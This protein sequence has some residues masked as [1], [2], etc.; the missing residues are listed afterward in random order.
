M[1][2][3]KTLLQ[4]HIRD[5]PDFPKPGILFKDITPALQDPAALRAVIDHLAAHYA[6]QS[7]DVIV[8]IESRGF[9]FG[10]ALAYAMNKGI[11]LVRKPGKLPWKTH[12]VSY[13]LEYGQDTLQ[14]H[15][16]AVAPGQRV[17]IVDDLLAT[18]GTAE[19]TCQLVEQ[20][21]GVVAG[22]AFLVELSFLEGRARLE[23]KAPYSILQ[24]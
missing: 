18:G 23:G 10:T 17:L 13:D 22:C 2:E 15:T 6:D 1:S 9:I 8:G 7:I 12:Q 3:L 16:D 4:T 11:S 20:C 14:I 5:V 19:A 21:G 24:Y